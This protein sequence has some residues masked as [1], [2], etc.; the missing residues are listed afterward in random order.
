[1]HTTSDD[2]IDFEKYDEPRLHMERLL[3][4]HLVEFDLSMR[5]LCPLER[6]GIRTLGDLVKQDRESLKKIFNIGKLSLER[7]ESFLSYHDL[8]LGMK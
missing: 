2:V 6:A 7:I 4:A 1:M 5:I 8:S 3:K